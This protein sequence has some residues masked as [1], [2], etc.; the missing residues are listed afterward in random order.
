L[1]VP[2]IWIAYSYHLSYSTAATA[3]VALSTG[4]V[5][6]RKGREV[7][8]FIEVQ[9][10]VFSQ[11]P[12]FLF[13]FEESALHPDHAASYRSTGTAIGTR[14]RYFAQLSRSR[15]FGFVETSSGALVIVRTTVPSHIQRRPFLER[16]IDYSV[17]RREITIQKP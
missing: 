7:S 8:Y 16:V 13:K 9:D 2:G 5:G 10:M 3:A 11:P 12:A 14:K 4:A 1:I 17:I 6:E 15:T